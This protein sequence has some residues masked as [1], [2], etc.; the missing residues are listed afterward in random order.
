M[1]AEKSRGMLTTP[2]I[3]QDVQCAGQ[4]YI[5]PV[6]FS[7][8]V[9]RIYVFVCTVCVSVAAVVNVASIRNVETGAHA[10]VSFCAMLLL[11]LLTSLILSGLARLTRL[12]SLV[13]LRTRLATST[14]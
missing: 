8:S 6:P 1:R 11:A 10:S 2:D 7:V 3:M 13:G 14:A 5:E 4:D 9:I 12:R